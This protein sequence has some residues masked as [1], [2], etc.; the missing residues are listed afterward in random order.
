[1]RNGGLGEG[2]GPCMKVYYSDFSKPLKEGLF[3]LKFGHKEVR[4]H[5]V[6]GS[7]RY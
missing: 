1:M 3:D 4:V 6:S 2:P 7:Y 5:G